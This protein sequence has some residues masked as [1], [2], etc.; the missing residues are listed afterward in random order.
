[1]RLPCRPCFQDFVLV[2]RSVV[3][4]SLLDSNL[5]QDEVLTGVEELG[6]IKGDFFI[7]TPP[8][9]SNVLTTLLVY[10]MI[11]ISRIVQDL[12]V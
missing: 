9:L 4:T 11:S 8:D 7:S 1:M 5:D 6:G 2:V 12:Q 3:P 10:F